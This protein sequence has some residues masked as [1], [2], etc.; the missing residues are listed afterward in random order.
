MYIT[1]DLSIRLLPFISS[2]VSGATDPQNYLVLVTTTSS[3]SGTRRFSQILSFH[4]GSS[5]G[6]P[7]GVTDHLPREVSRSL[8]PPKRD[9]L[10]FRGAV[11]LLQAPPR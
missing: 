5:L 6:S 3:S 4:Q 10:Y 9:L 11:A 7:S 8:K 2:Q 1:I